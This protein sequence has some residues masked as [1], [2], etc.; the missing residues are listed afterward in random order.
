MDDC[1]WVSVCCGVKPHH[2]VDNM[3]SKCMK[4]VAFECEVCIDGRHR[5]VTS[6]SLDC[7]PLSLHIMKAVGD[8]LKFYRSGP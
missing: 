2:W 6:G 4:L 7:D 8:V 5:D 1:E 3:C